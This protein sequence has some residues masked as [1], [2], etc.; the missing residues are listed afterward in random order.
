MNTQGAEEWAEVLPYVAARFIL[1][2]WILGALIMALLHRPKQD[3]KRLV[4]CVKPSRNRVQDL[5]ESLRASRKSAITRERI[6]SRIHNLACDMA[7]LDLGKG[8]GVT[9][10]SR[11]R[12]SSS[13]DELLRSYQE[14]FRLA[15]PAGEQQKTA[16]ALSFLERTA[17]VIAHLEDIRMNRQGEK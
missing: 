14:E 16:H 10:P 17:Q 11:E 15:F 9:D 2:L 7:T 4:L 13:N 3:W 8:K 1:A 6:A 5:A 12:E